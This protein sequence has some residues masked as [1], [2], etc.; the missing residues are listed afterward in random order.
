MVFFYLKNKWFCLSKA[1][2][3]VSKS[4]YF[5]LTIILTNKEDGNRIFQEYEES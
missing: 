1:Y 5:I 2:K 4:Y 3:N